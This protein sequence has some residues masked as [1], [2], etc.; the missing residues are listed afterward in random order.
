MR[1][2]NITVSTL[3][4]ADILLYVVDTLR[5][6]GEEEREIAELVAS[7]NQSVVVALTKSIKNE[8]IQDLCS[9]LWKN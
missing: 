6:P 2:K 9:S 7:G 1:L 8:L 3:G 5:K 4:D